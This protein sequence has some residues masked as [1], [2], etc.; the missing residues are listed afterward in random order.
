[1]LVVGLPAK[2]DA[3][4]R[5]ALAGDGADPDTPARQVGR[6]TLSALTDTPNPQALRQGFVLTSEVA[7]LSGGRVFFPKGVFRYRSHEEAN[8]HQQECR[9]QG[10][11]RLALERERG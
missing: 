3:L 5:P 1:M 9:A 10:M 4:Q 11:A 8:S 7:R 6:R 2:P